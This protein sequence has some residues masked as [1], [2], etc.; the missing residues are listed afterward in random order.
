MV[1]ATVHEEIAAAREATA[2]SLN[3]SARS[4]RQAAILEELRGA[5]WRRAAEEL[6]LEPEQ[7][8]E[9]RI[10]SVGQI[11]MPPV[12]AAAEDR[13]RLRHPQPRSRGRGAG[14]DAGGDEPKRLYLFDPASGRSLQQGPPQ[15][16][17]EARDDVA[18]Q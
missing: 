1:M 16:A 18:A 2:A 7:R 8:D 12:D 9:R 17:M 4:V 3:I 10:A 6:H 13:R 15:G 5:A 14:V 11:R